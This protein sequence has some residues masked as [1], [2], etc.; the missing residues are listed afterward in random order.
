MDRG[1]LNLE[2]VSKIAW[3][4]VGVLYWLL[5][6][7]PLVREEIRTEP[8]SDPLTVVRWLPAHR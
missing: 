6:T 4:C 2:S 3:M 7:E 1:L 5:N 8:K